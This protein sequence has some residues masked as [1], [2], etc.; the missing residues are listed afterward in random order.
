MVPNVVDITRYFLF[1]LRLF[2]SILLA[3]EFHHG[4]VS[5]RAIELDGRAHRRADHIAANTH[6][7]S[8]EDIEWDFANEVEAVAMR[9]YNHKEHYP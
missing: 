9:E 5:K 3:H 1:Q 6:T 7:S 4:F 8:P 2:I